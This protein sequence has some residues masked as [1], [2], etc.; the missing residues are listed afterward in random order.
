MLNGTY[1][2][3][4]SQR[5][6]KGIANRDLVLSAMAQIKIY[7]PPMELQNQF[8]DFVK[9]VNKSRVVLQF[10]QKMANL[11]SKYR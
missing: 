8:A 11:L 6:T 3:E 4:Q 9:Q 1:C 7:C 10:T 5:L 2:Y